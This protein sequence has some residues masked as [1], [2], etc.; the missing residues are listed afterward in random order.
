MDLRRIRTRLR[1]GQLDLRFTDHALI[2]V[3]KDGLTA[4]DLE[5]AAMHGEL[6][7]DY[8]VR[9]LLMSFTTQD[10]LPCHV[11]IEYESLDYEVTVVTAYVPDPRDWQ[12]GWKRRK[13]AKTVGRCQEGCRG[14]L[15]AT[16]VTRVFQRRSSPVEVILENIPAD[17]CSVCGRAFFSRQTARDIDRV[18]VPFHGRHREIPNLPPARVIVDFPSATKK[19]AA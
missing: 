1:S 3:R 10:A 19:R 13:R 18:L 9:A 11:V 15:T 2:E 6:I 4:D 7:E 12:K 8:A 14:R 17:V 5:D 16:T